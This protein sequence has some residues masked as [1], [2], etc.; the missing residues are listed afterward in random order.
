MGGLFDGDFPTAAPGERSEP[1]VA[2]LF[3]GLAV[4]VY[5]EPGVDLVAGAA[6]AAFQHLLAGADG[7]A[8]EL[9]LARP[10][11][12]EVAEA[13][14][15]A[16]REVPRRRLG[17]LDDQGPGGGVADGGL[18]AE[19]PCFLV[20]FVGQG[21]VDVE[22]D[23][24]KLNFQGVG[25][26][27]VADI[28]EDQVAVAVGERNFEGG[29]GVEAGAPAWVFL[30]RSGG[31]EIE[32]RPVAGG[33]RGG[34][35]GVAVEALAP[36][37]V[38]EFLAAVDAK[39]IG[40]VPASRTKSLGMARYRTGFWAKAGRVRAKRAIRALGDTRIAYRVPRY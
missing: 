19:D 27:A 34:E 6:A 5:G 22:L 25:L 28:V 13:I 9:G 2:A 32:G 12:S 8:L 26:D 40:G 35:V 29:F 18:A 16:G 20:H 15:F 1:D 7:S 21:D 39:D 30:R 33:L 36:V 37:D 17:A 14:A 4:A 24:L 11:S 3:A 23:V 10:S 38:L 31:G